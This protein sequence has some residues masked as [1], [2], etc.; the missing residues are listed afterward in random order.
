MANLLC[1]TRPR[2]DANSL[3][4]LPL[5]AG[6]TTISLAPNPGASAELTPLNIYSRRSHGI[7][8]FPPL[9]NTLNDDARCATAK[10]ERACVVSNW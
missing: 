9:S 7:A 3:G 2:Q 6:S 8:L 4:A 5:G 1:R 10:S